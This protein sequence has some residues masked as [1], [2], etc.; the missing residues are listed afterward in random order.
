M[1]SF[2]SI[3]RINMHEVISASRVSDPGINMIIYQ[4][5]L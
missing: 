4:L 1:N 3:S 5:L 2:D